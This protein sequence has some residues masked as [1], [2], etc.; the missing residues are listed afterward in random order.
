MPVTRLSTIGTP[1]PKL[2]GRLVL[3]Q[4]HR[5]EGLKQPQARLVAEAS[6]AG[7]LVLAAAAAGSAATGSSPIIAMPRRHAAICI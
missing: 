3:V 5:H 7:S 6:T 2:G 4:E 1:K